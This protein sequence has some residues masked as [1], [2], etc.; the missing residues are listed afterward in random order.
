MTEK[1]I[2]D[3]A[4][5]MLGKTFCRLEGGMLFD[6]QGQP[7]ALRAKSLLFLKTLL[8]R[9]GRIVSK[10]ELAETVWSGLIVSDE[11]ISQCVADIRRFL[12]DENR[13]VLETFPKQGYRIN[14]AKF[15]TPLTNTR[16]GKFALVAAII[17][18]LVAL[19]GVLIFQKTTV[20]TPV[21]REVIAVFP[22]REDDG[23]TE[24]SYFASVFAEELN[25]KLAELSGF[26][27]IPNSVSS[28]IGDDTEL[29]TNRAEA[30]GARYAVDSWIKSSDLQFRIV[31][32]LIDVREHKVLW[33]SSFEGTPE[34]LL[35]IRDEIIKS[36]TLEIFDK[37][38][39]SDRSRIAQKETSNPLAYEE[40]LRGK[41]AGGT[42]TRDDSLLAERHFRRAIELDPDYARAY[43]E[44]AALFAIRFE[45]GWITL[46][47]ADEIKSLH[48]ANTAIARN[49]DLWLAHYA[50]G[51]LHT[52]IGEKDYEMAEHH[53]ERAISLQ[54]ANED[55]RAYFGAVKNLQG[56]VDLA[57]TILEQAIA[58]HPSPPF[59]YYLSLGHALFHAKR[60]EDAAIAL[61]QC[62]TQMP[63]APY[64]LRFQIANYGAMGQIEDAEWAADEYELLGFEA[65]ISSIMSLFIIQ[66]P[67][68]LS[69]L[70]TALRV[71]GLP[72]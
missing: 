41:H 44:L 40:V 55:A 60:Y 39:P 67:A 64:C 32:E 35:Q 11:S 65:S 70:E 47:E 62:L 33:A 26:S 42:I 5:F 61:E 21:L 30:L 56:E 15:A 18:V 1:P 25:G 31:V 28:T 63:T 24:Q 14:V 10:S 71:A 3:E 16:Q 17:A 27:V 9:H 7:I 59:W 45:N 2:L 54:P 66:D 36:I 53:L 23:A 46:N 22:L 51:R 19:I 20:P 72:E 57:I 58:S 37:L 6:D 38:N 4:G 50:L 52:V 12:G 49:P 8:E 29:A 68:A 43:A 69:N 13:A 34:Q 48:F